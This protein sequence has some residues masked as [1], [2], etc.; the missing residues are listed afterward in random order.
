MKMAESMT[1]FSF[2]IATLVMLF[3][4]FILSLVIAAILKRDQDVL[5]V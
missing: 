5:D 1:G 2:V 4:G 3:F